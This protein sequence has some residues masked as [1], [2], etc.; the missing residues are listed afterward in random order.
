[1]TTQQAKNI[2]L[3]ILLEKMGFQSTRSKHNGNDVWYKSP[4]RPNERDASFHVN[5]RENVWYDFGSEIGGDV[6]KFVQE[7][8]K[9]ETADALI[10]LD[11]L[12]PENAKSDKLHDGAKK[13]FDRP[14]ALSLKRAQPISNPHLVT[15]LKEDR[16][17]D[18][19]TAQKHLIEVIY[20]QI[21]TGKEYY[22]LGMAN[23]SGGFE[24]R[25]KY[26]KGS[27]FEKDIT[28]LPAKSAADT[29]INP[30]N[31]VSIFEG[32]FD[33]LSALK[34]YGDTLMEGEVIVMHS[35]A[36]QNATIAY[37]T[38]RDFSRIYTYFD[39]DRAGEELTYAIGKHFPK[40]FE[41]CSA[42][43][44]PHKDFNEFWVSKKSH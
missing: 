9:F 30:E 3:S 17:I 24:I 27:L 28:I 12:F 38:A 23:R 21:Q 35:V 7:F 19:K 43:F 25:N 20:A 16:K 11:V 14:E 32:F 10:F 5:V 22:A 18:L 15:Y 6:L 8:N 37:L 31:K 42:L 29:P 34:F 2:P 33:F 36:M 26:F 1:V 4:F 39:N 41:P 13:R 40:V 44:Y